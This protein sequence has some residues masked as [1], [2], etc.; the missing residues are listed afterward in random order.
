MNKI[1]WIQKQLD[2]LRK[3]LHLQTQLEKIQTE[4]GEFIVPNP[5]YK[6][7]R[8]EIKNGTRDVRIPIN[9]DGIDLF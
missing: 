2:I 9:K 7:K 8:N 6:D 1:S 3:I 4:E 5:D